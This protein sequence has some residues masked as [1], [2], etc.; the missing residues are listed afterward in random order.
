MSLIQEEACVQIVEAEVG[1]L[2]I[3]MQPLFQHCVWTTKWLL[4]NYAL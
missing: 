3:K 1:L 2:C 4:P